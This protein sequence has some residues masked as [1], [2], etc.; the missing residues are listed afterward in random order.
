MIIIRNRWL[1][2]GR[3]AA[4]NICGILFVRKGCHITSVLLNHE[5]IHSRQVC[6]MLV[7]PFYLWYVIEWLFHLVRCRSLFTAYRRIRFEREA[8]DH[9]TDLQYLTH[10]HPFAWLR[11]KQ[12]R[13]RQ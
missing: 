7:L 1:P 6:E 3:F 12:D 13:D 2:V 9:E 5:Q 8:Y 4:I 10:R 11:T